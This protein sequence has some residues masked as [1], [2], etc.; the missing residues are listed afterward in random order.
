MK[1]ARLMGMRYWL[2]CS[3]II[4]LS[5]G[6]S[7]SAFA[8]ISPQNMSLS[9]S[10]MSDAVMVKNVLTNV[11]TPAQLRNLTTPVESS[12]SPSVKSNPNPNA[13]PVGRVVWVKGEFTASLKS[14]EVIEPARSLEKSSIIYL[15]DTLVTGN[16]SEAQIVFSDNT[17]MTFRPESKFYIDEY[18]YNAN[19]KTKSVGKYVM[20]LI[21]GGFRTITG[22][23]AKS[24]P[25]DYQVNTPVAT[26]GVRGTDYTLIIK[27]KGVYI[28]RNKGEPCVRNDVKN[29]CLNTENKYA[30]VSTS[31]SAPT[32]IA[33]PPAFLVQPIVIEP[34]T[35][36]QLGGTPAGVGVSD[37]CI[38]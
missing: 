27:D 34:A 15:H 19:A 24:N 4:G 21:E 22:I 35:F 20:S 36:G 23:I 37:F 14:A 33:E 3:V 31:G 7:F 8:E 18:A 29:L 32:Y 25:S 5:L 12:T 2:G 30:E 13:Q 10:G 6:L 17:L 38:R 11:T 1:K 28:A 26:I 9:A 16:Q